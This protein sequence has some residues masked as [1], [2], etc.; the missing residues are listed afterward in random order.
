MEVISLYVI[1]NDNEEKSYAVFQSAHVPQPN[2][3]IDLNTVEKP[4]EYASYLV[5]SVRWTAGGA[6]PQLYK[7]RSATLRVKPLL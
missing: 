1:D 7:M 3:V 4:Y 2:N 5:I 6:E